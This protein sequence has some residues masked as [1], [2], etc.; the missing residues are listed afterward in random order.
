M[1]LSNYAE[2]AAITWLFTG[3][4]VTRPVGPFTIALHFGDPGEDGTANE[5]TATE[6]TDY[7]RKTI[8]FADPVA[9]TGRSLSSNAPSWTIGA[10]TGFTLTHISI[11]EDGTSDNL[12][13]GPLLVPVALVETD[14][15]THSAGKV[16]AA[17]L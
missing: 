14:V 6:D 11:W 1:S 3:T 2:D 12:I 17:L 13:S 10:G 16:I 9:G 4:A 5:V 8:T 15:H 7:V